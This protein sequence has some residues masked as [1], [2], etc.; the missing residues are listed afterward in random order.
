MDRAWFIQMANKVSMQSVS[1]LNRRLWHCSSRPHVSKAFQSSSSTTENPYLKKYADKIASAQGV[2]SE[3]F[4]IPAERSLP[5]YENQRKYSVTRPY[6]DDEQTDN[7]YSSFT[8]ISQESLDSIMKLEL[9][10]NKTADEIEFIWKQFF[11][12]KDGLYAVI[13]S[14]TY[15]QII[16]KAEQFPTFL[17][18]V[19]KE[20]GYVFI[21]GQFKGNSCYFASLQ[22]YKMHKDSAHVGLTITY[23]PELIEEKGIA[24]MRGE[25]D[26]E[27]LRVQ[28]AQC[29]ANQLQ[30]YY[31]G[32]DQ[33]KEKLLNVFNYYPQKFEYR[34]LISE[35]ETVIG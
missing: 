16:S 18:P 1:L 23:Y 17:Y 12:E 26:N 22:D 10:R 2:P 34:D 31:G 30:L 9:L 4:Q 21:V 3:N 25:F 5:K 27:V 14:A 33:K 6:L 13:P 15:H 7:S 32:S 28:E 24:L 11:G 29:L 20:S 8:R 35:L 19:P